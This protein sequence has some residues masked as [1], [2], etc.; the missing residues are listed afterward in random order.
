MKLVKLIIELILGR[1]VSLSRKGTDYVVIEWDNDFSSS[2]ENIND[3]ILN[4]KLSHAQF[5]RATDLL[6]Q[7]QKIDARIDTSSVTM[8]LTEL[9]PEDL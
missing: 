2:T 4:K 5:N 8:S 3:L 1:V 6:E 7:L 9:S